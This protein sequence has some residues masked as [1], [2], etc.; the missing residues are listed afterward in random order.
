MTKVVMLYTCWTEPKFLLFLNLR[1][2]LGEEF[3]DLLIWH[4]MFKKQYLFNFPFTF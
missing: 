2:P 1:N 3:I 4:L